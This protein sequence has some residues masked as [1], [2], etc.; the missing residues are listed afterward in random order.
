M[1]LFVHQGHKVH[2]LRPSFLIEAQLRFEN[3]QGQKALFA[4][5]AH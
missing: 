4:R 1:A 5:G 3:R 2:L